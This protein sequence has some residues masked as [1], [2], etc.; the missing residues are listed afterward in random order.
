MSLTTTQKA[1]LIEKLEVDRRNLK[2][3]INENKYLTE[4]TTQFL[5]QVLDKIDN[6]IFDL[7]Y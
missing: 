5:E 2:M 4:Q 6:L 1:E 3:F 7:E